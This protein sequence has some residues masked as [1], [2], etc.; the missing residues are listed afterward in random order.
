MGRGGRKPPFFIMGIFNNTRTS[1]SATTVPV[2]DVEAD[3][4]KESVLRSL[5]RKKS[6]IAED[7]IKDTMHGMGSAM[8]RVF[9]YGKTQYYHGLPIADLE[10]LAADDSLILE[11]LET[12]ETDTV[13]LTS[14]LL[15]RNEPVFFLK[16]YLATVRDYNRLTGR[17]PYI[18][19]DIPSQMDTAYTNY[20]AE[21]R[22]I[23]EARLDTLRAS[24][25]VDRTVERNVVTPE[26]NAV[27]VKVYEVSSTESLVQIPVED[28]YT[29]L[30]T[31]DLDALPEDKFKYT[32]DYNT[33]LRI[34]LYSGSSINYTETVT[35]YYRY[36][37]NSESERTVEVFNRDPLTAP[38]VNLVKLFTFP[39]SEEYFPEYDIDRLYYYIEYLTEDENGLFTPK[40][41]LFY[42]GFGGYPGFPTE[43]FLSPEPFYPV[44]TLRK[45][46][47]D[48]F[49]ESRIEEEE[50][51]STKKMLNL[52]NIDPVE[53][54]E[55]INDNPDIDEIDHAYLMFGVSLATTNNSCIQYLCRFFEF[56]A[57]EEFK[58]VDLSDEDF[59]VDPIDGGYRDKPEDLTRLRFYEGG[60]NME[61]NWSKINVEYIQGSIGKT[62]NA[63]KE[64][65]TEND[66]AYILKLY[67]QIDADTYLYIEVYGLRHTNFIISSYYTETTIKDVFDNPDNSNFIIPIRSSFVEEMSSFDRDTLFYD[68]LHLVFYSYEVTKLKWYETDLFKVFLIIITVIVIATT[69]QAWAADLLLAIEGGVL[70]TL[71]FITVSI[72]ETLIIQYIFE[73]A[74]DALGE[75]LS[76]VVAVLATVAAIYGYNVDS[77][78]ITNNWADK[79]LAASANITKAIDS[80]LKEDMA[81][82]IKQINAFQD[83]AKDL[84][85][86]LEQK[87][88]LLNFDSIL[89]PFMFISTRPLINVNESPNEFFGRTVH[90]GNPGVLAY[91]NL[92]NYVD[93]QLNLPKPPTF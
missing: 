60:L 67:H 42:E 47:V 30:S 25:P 88:E 22:T 10:F 46:N 79:L 81:D 3:S 69:G 75:K 40:H 52:I 72:L 41:L 57:E 45:E 89:D 26:G 23:E 21:Q 39:H 16:D 70:A 27:E 61:V 11:Y 54:S 5:F 7:L 37:D 85:D 73:L 82:L 33:T 84:M 6:N 49:D 20:L 35:T 91:E 29:L 63:K 62:G 93:M 31:T 59:V 74:V 17:S 66:E 92:T 87:Q 71:S 18:P 8:Q 15:E 76:F 68:S 36:S 48:L 38:T 9:N 58:L 12:T 4:I 14:V 2:M 43:R 13:K 56:Y 78:L 90:Q 19:D 28:R 51:Q 64:I 86:E 1:V 34:D 32:I 44:V 83:Q 77:S 65:M 24:L 53:L 80:S 55:N 50:Y